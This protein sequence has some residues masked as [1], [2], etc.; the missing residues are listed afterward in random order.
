MGGFSYS[1]AIYT[2][3]FSLTA[4]GTDGWLN[5]L[6]ASRDRDGMLDFYVITKACQSQGMLVCYS[7]SE[8]FK[9]FVP[10]LPPAAA[11]IK[12]FGWKPQKK[13][14]KKSL[15]SRISFRAESKSRKL[16]HIRIVEL[17]KH[18]KK[19][20]FWKHTENLFLTPVEKRGVGGI[21]NGTEIEKAS[22]QQF[23]FHQFIYE[24][25]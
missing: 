9:V 21:P 19:C 14:S 17:S 10:I 25:F 2:P 8:T 3:L 22:Q 7:L 23:V 12:S 11:A 18:I 6:F 15:A 1:K 20:C 4:H 24:A 13:P 5:I 16:C